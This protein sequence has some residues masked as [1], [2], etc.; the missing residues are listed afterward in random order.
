MFTQLEIG[1]GRFHCIPRSEFVVI[2]VHH[3]RRTTSYILSKSVHSTK[4]LECVGL[5]IFQK[6][7][8]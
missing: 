8:L 1:R 4:K 7:L 5:Q 6:L 2:Y 3:L